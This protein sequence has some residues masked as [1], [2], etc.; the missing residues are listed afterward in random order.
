MAE[1]LQV[2]R[3]GHGEGEWSLEGRLSRSEGNSSRQ[4]L[5]PQM[6]HRSPLLCRWHPRGPGIYHPEVQKPLGY[7]GPA[8]YQSFTEA[9]SQAQKR[10]LT[11]TRH[12]VVGGG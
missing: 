9:E 7:P 3:G 2:A 1:G 6:G 8:F 4:V 5:L 10:P 12:P 11:R